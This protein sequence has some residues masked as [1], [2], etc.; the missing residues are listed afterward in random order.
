MSCG[1]G[2]RHGRPGG[3]IS[4]VCPGVFISGGDLYTRQALFCTCGNGGGGKVNNGGG[5][6]VEVIIECS[7]VCCLLFRVCVVNCGEQ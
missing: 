1:G 6:K 4:C 7:I 3:R 2:S 5:G